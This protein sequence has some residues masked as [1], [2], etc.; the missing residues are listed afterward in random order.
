[1]VQRGLNETY[2]SGGVGSF[3]LQLMALSFL[4]H[5]PPTGND[6]NLGALL[7]DFFELY[8]RKLNYDVRESMTFDLVL[9][10]ALCSRR[11]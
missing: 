5:R 11:S 7:L 2:P 9:S 8:G 3:L 1:L 10:L 6:L 4:Q